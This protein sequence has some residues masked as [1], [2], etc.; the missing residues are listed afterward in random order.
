M[1]TL[2][3]LHKC[4]SGR[5]VDYFRAASPGNITFTLIL[6]FVV[7]YF[8]N[9]LLNQLFGTRILPLGQPV[10]FMLILFSIIPV[11]YIVIRRQGS[12]E[13][14]DFFTIGLIAA[15]TFAL[16]YYLPTLI[17]EIF[18]N[19][20]NRVLSILNSMYTDP[21]NPIAIWYNSS[22]VIHNTIQSVVPIP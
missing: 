2:I 19:P 16:I 14:Q 6:S 10:R 4:K 5:F 15:G 11:F 22:T 9:F 7:L 20:S 1:K 17:P 8:G 21:G 18:T 3:R 13:R 12:L